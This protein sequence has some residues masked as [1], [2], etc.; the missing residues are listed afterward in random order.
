[1]TVY[2]V[3]SLPKLRYIHRIYMVLGQPIYRAYQ[4]NSNWRNKKVGKPTD[5]AH[6]RLQKVNPVKTVLL[7]LALLFPSKCI[8]STR[9]EK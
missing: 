5:Q 2:L 8:K 7:R 1:M 6:C 3:I 9:S 4:H